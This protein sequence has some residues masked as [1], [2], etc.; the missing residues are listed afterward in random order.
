MRTK[1]HWEE[2]KALLSYHVAQRV[3][4]QLK[5]LARDKGYD[6]RGIKVLSKEQSHNN[7]RISDSEV[8]WD[9]GPRNWP[10]EFELVEYPGVWFESHDSSSISFYDI[11]HT[12]FKGFRHENNQY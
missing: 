3:A 9:E 1:R 7:G 11:L 5:E 12:G 2:C 4:L 8:M 10:E 6:P